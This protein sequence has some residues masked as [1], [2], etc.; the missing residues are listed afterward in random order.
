MPNPLIQVSNLSTCPVMCRP[1]LNISESL[2]HYFGKSYTITH[3]GK[4]RYTAFPILRC[5]RTTGQVR[6]VMAQK[7][8]KI[9]SLRGACPPCLRLWLWQVNRKVEYNELHCDESST[10]TFAQLRWINCYGGTTKQ[11]IAGATT[12]VIARRYDER[13]C[14]EV[15][16]SNEIE[17]GDRV[18]IIGRNGALR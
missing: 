14:E 1:V 7:V 6:D 10:P 17:Q 11:V 4:E 5:L 13:H 3:E 9:F 12:N 8:K 16:R 15:R 18:G 2:W